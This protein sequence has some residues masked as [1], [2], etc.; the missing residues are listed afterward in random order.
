MRCSSVLDLHKS[1]TLKK[2][3]NINFLFFLICYTNEL[4]CPL[5]RILKLSER[6]LD[7]IRFFVEIELY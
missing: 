2:Q 3:K 5:A 7:S 1:T 4:G 6:C